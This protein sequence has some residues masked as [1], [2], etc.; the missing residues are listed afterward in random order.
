MEKYIYIC[1]AKFILW[2]DYKK[3]A[4]HFPTYKLIR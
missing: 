2:T 4:P 1:N 3:V